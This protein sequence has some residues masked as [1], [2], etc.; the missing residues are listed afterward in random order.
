MTYPGPNAFNHCIMKF[1]QEYLPTL[2]GM[3]AHT[4]HSYRDALVLYIRFV[5]ADGERHIERLDFDQFGP[6]SAALESAYQS[7]TQPA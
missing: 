6:S 5:T 3:S 2:R 7:M 1:F 4:I